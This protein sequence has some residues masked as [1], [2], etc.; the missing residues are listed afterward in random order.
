MQFVIVWKPASYHFVAYEDTTAVW[1]EDRGT[2]ATE[3][4]EFAGRWLEIPESDP[5]YYQYGLLPH[6]DGLV[7]GVG[8]AGNSDLTKRVT[9][10]AGR[11]VVAIHDAADQWTLYVAA[12]G[13]PYPVRIHGPDFD[14]HLSRYNNHFPV[15]VPTGAVPI[16]GVGR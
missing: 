10:L 14:L 11:N 1:W 8:G 13:T 16:S 5:A 3:A 7:A 15:A 6:V 4:G 9:T 12:T 2:S